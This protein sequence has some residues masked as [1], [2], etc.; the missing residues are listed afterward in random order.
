MVGILW[1]I[2]V[3]EKSIFLCKFKCPTRMHK[4]Q[5]H[6]QSW[7]RSQLPVSDS[8]FLPSKLENVGP[9]FPFFPSLRLLQPASCSVLLCSGCLYKCHNWV[10]IHPQF[11]PSA[12]ANKQTRRPTKMESESRVQLDETNNSHKIPLM[13]PYKMGKFDLSHRY[14]CCS[15]F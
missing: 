10:F 4:R 8:L 3:V 2:L 11:S 6:Q 7:K 15:Y 1:S 13:T 12:T 14:C 9:T 5:Q